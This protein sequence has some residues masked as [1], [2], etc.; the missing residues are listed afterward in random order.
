MIFNS[1]LIFVSY[2][3][4]CCI[5]CPIQIPNHHH[6]HHHHHHHPSP[7]EDIGCGSSIGSWVE[8]T[9]GLHTIMADLYNI[10]MPS[11][12]DYIRI[13]PESLKCSKKDW[14]QGS[15]R[16][17]QTGGSSWVWFSRVPPPSDFWPQRD[18]LHLTALSVQSWEGHHL[19]ACHPSL[20]GH[21]WWVHGRVP[22]TCPTIPE[23]WKQ[24]EVE[25]GLR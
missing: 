17:E 10:D 8:M 5:K 6:H 3:S 25:F 2:S 14:P 12:R 15:L 4:E 16:W 20:Q 22:V 1:Y 23:E 21:Y 24:L 7:R 9:R 11:R 18:L 19:Q 13:T